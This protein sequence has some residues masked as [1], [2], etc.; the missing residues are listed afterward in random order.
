MKFSASFQNA[1]LLQTVTVLGGESYE[2][3]EH[4]AYGAVHW[5][6][7]LFACLRPSGAQAAFL[8]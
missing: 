5:L 8:G 7:L 6:S 1:K 2:N 3:F 4:A